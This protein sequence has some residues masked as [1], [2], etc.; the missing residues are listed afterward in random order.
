MPCYQSL[1]DTA[2]AEYT[3]AN[4]PRVPFGAEMHRWAHI[5]TLDIASKATRAA[6]GFYTLG[7][8][9][10]PSIVEALHTPQLLDLCRNVRRVREGAVS[11]PLTTVL[12]AICLVWV[13]AVWWVVEI[14]LV[15][16]AEKGFSSVRAFLTLPATRP[17]ALSVA[18][19]VAA[20]DTT[21]VKIHSSMGGAPV[22]GVSNILTVATNVRRA[23]W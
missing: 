1:S 13:A 19:T 2:T 4:A 16:F 20:G 12:V 21:D 3:R 17:T 8:P 23:H 7:E 15:F 6:T 9:V 14:M 5:G 11:V 18:L 10:D 22:I